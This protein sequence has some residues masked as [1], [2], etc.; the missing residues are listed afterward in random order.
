MD[1]DVALAQLIHALE[2]GDLDDA[3]DNFENLTEW[4]EN[5]GFPPKLHRATSKTIRP[6]SNPG[7]QRIEVYYD[8]TTPESVDAGDFSESGQYTSIDIEPDPEYEETVVDV[9]I[10][11]LENKVISASSSEWHP[12]IWYQ[13]E[14]GV[15]SYETGEEESN[16]YHLKGFTQEQEQEIY[17]TLK[18]GGSI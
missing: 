12:G 17:D 11:E 15:V 8:R 7:G 13:G 3:E 6:S 5:G 1:P 18:S 14:W 10:G 16:T 4:I 2:A 9:A